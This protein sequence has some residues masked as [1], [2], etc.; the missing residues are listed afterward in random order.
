MV[1]LATCSLWWIVAANPLSFSG[2]WLPSS[3]SHLITAVSGGWVILALIFSYF[4]FK[5]STANIH[6]NVL[7]KFLKNTLYLDKIYNEI[8]IKGFLTLSNSTSSI[9]RKLIDAIIHGTAYAQVTLA[10]FAAWFDRIF[11]D[12]S[13]NGVAYFSRGVGRL[14]RSTQGGMIQ[15]YIF[16]AGLGLIGL[17]LYLVF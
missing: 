4:I 9:D 15:L 1:I 2:W 5:K 17:M 6:E 16:W 13:V 3:A 12:G 11:V 8:F 7:T 10:H 14:A